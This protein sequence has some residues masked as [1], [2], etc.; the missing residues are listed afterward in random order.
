MAVAGFFPQVGFWL[1]RI[2]FRSRLPLFLT[3]CAVVSTL[4]S[5]LFAYFVFD[6]MPHIQDEIAM[7]FQAKI[8]ATGRVTPPAP[9][10]G[11]FF[12]CEFIIQNAGRWYGK[13]FIGQAICLVPGEW[14]GMPWLVHPILGGLVVWLTYAIGAGLWNDRLGRLG[15][16]LMTVSPFRMVIFAM[17]LGHAS[18][19]MMLGLFALAMVK[20]VR[21]PRRWGWGLTGGLALGLAGNARPLTA[22]SIG[23]A[24]CLVTAIALPW[25]RLTFSSVLAF[26]AGLGFFVAVL[27]LYNQALTGHPRL[28]PF[29]QWSRTDRLGFGPE[30]GL[31]YWREQDKGHTLRKGLLKD[32]YFNLE[33]LRANEMG[34][35]G[36]VLL[37]MAFPVFIKRY[38]KLG[39][40][41]VAA[42]VAVAAA[43]TSCTYRTASWPGRRG[44]GRSRCP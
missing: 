32:V 17:V 38:Y 44:T 37:L 14:V 41:L 29:N 18:S 26:S 4:L 35:G 15:A 33:A 12:D 24:I 39:L 16:L 30:V 11:D 23:V 6:H 2:V 7:E 19:L 34:W 20:L 21:D 43:T 5:A 31:E 9:K 25:R 10:L 13:Y 1:D 42:P 28:T 22:L 36:V 8:L 40:A 27:F 3:S